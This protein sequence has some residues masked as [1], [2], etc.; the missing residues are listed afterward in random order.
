[1]APAVPTPAAT[2]AVAMVNETAPAPAPVS[3][4]SPQAAE[5]PRR[6]RGRRER[7]PV[8]QNAAR[9]AVAQER[10]PER[11]AAEHQRGPQPVSPRDGD[12]RRVVGFGAD[13]P[14][15]LARPAPA[16]AAARE[17]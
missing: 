4:A 11:P 2:P 15:F 7:K 13:L 5:R 14:A 3:H 8:E 16:S 1:M 12:D 9:P 17:E 6:Q 10:L